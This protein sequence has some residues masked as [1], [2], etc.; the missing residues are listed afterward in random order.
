[1]TAIG[2]LSMSYVL[3]QEILTPYGD[4]GCKVSMSDA[5][6]GDANQGDT[7]VSGDAMWHFEAG[8]PTTTYWKNVNFPSATSSYGGSGKQVWWKIPPLRRGCTVILMEAFQ[9]LGHG[10]VDPNQPLGNVI[11]SAQRG[12][13]L[14]SSLEVSNTLHY[15]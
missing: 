12:G 2:L 6:R 3:S 7:D 13:C 4:S 14:Y 15:T 10:I 5:T 8:Y 11:I 1:M 9:V